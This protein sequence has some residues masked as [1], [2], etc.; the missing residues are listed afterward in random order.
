MKKKPHHW[1]FPVPLEVIYN[2][3]LIKFPAKNTHGNTNNT[4]GC[5]NDKK[6]YLKTNKNT[7][8]HK[9]L[10]SDPLRSLT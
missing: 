3:S 6:N 9:P 1:N 2:I 4:H 10:K 8:E 5:S 7:F